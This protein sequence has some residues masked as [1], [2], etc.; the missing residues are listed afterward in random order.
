MNRQTFTSLEFLLVVLGNVA[1]F[2][3]VVAGSYSG[4][5]AAYLTAASVAGYAII[6]GAAKLN[7]DLKD[8]WKTTEFWL[9][10]LGSIPA[11]VEAFRSLIPGHTYGVV[12]AAILLALGIAQGLRKVP[13]VQAGIIGVPQAASFDALAAADGNDA[14]AEQARRAA[15]ATDTHVDPPTS[16]S[17]PKAPRRRP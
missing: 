12:Q 11:A 6:R 8:Y 13:A 14:A 2:L 4:T 5:T 7:S 17:P 16:G 3:A 15:M 10:I 1:N 9:A